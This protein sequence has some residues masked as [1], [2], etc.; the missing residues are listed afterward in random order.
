M[1]KQ[2]RR[3]A[4]VCPPL[5]YKSAINTSNDRKCTKGLTKTNSF[6][7]SSTAAH[8]DIKTHVE[9]Y[10]HLLFTLSWEVSG[11]NTFVLCMVATGGCNA[12]EGDLVG[13]TGFRLSIEESWVQRHHHCVQCESRKSLNRTGVAGEL[14][15]S[16]MLPQ[17]NGK[18]LFYGSCHVSTEA[19]NG[20]T[21]PWLC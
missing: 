6:S 2:L 9:F 7:C 14:T 1:S 13:L 15:L 12:A 4:G 17:K 21:T 16:T 19:Q 11:Q 3:F 8:V 18:V 5:L 20:Q 10:F